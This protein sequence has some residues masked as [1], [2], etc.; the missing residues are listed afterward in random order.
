MKLQGAHGHPPASL[1]LAQNSCLDVQHRQSKY[2]GQQDR[3]LSA[4]DTDLPTKA[5]KAPVPV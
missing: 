1:H 2:F 5:H 3:I 4:A